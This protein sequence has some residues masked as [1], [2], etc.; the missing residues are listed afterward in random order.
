M[1]FEDTTAKGDPLTSTM[2]YQRKGYF[3]F[4]GFVKETKLPLSN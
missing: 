3:V 4:V 1:A 2:K